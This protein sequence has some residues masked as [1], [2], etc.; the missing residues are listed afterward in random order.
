MKYFTEIDLK[1]LTSSYIVRLFCLIFFL[2][3]VTGDV[4]GNTKD[5]NIN[6]INRFGQF[7]KRHAAIWESHKAVSKLCFD[8]FNIASV[9]LEGNWDWRRKVAF[10][11]HAEVGSIV[12]GRFTDAD[13]LYTD[14][15]LENQQLF[16]LTDSSVNDGAL[17]DVNIGVGH[18]FVWQKCCLQITPLVGIHYRYL[19]ICIGNARLCYPKLTMVDGEDAQNRYIALD[20]SIWSR[21]HSAWIGFDCRWEPAQRMILYGKC[22]YHGGFLYQSNHWNLR[23]RR[24]RELTLGTGFVGEVRW[25]YRWGCKK[26]LG[27]QVG[28]EHWGSS[29]NF[30]D[31]DLEPAYEQTKH[32]DEERKWENVYVGLFYSRCF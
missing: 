12:S 15:A 4:F 20:S 16:V 18:T 22:Q 5:L 31:F 3:S 2:V 11:L 23:S 17:A 14:D 10:Y 26:I 13:Y 27:I 7:S 21:W 1:T 25:G 29:V 28:Y 30:A 6:V 24:F 8:N 32:A 9:Y 19:G